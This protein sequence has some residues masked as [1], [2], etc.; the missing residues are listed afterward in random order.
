M[1]GAQDAGEYYRVVPGQSLSS[2]VRV[3]ETEVAHVKT[4]REQLLFVNRNSVR[5]ENRQSGSCE[6]VHDCGEHP[7][8]AA[9]SQ[10]RD[11]AL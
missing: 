5:R 10:R 2:H 1:L 3:C 11:V 6:S 4:M 9:H 7:D 8:M